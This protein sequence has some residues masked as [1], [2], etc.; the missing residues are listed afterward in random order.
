MR[1]GSRKLS[2][3]DQRDFDLLPAR[4]EEIDR[5]VAR[6]EAALADRDL[7]A[8]DPATF[9]RLTAAIDR[10]RAEKD[11]AEERWLALAEQVEAQG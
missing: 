8:R 2:Y 6:D 5:A 9:A 3:K 1:E 7:Y 11:A 10:A 4:I